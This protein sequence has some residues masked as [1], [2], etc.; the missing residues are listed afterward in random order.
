V[1]LGITSASRVAFVRNGK[2][3]DNREPMADILRDIVEALRIIAKDL[4]IIEQRIWKLE[5]E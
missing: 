2:I 3:V 4:E 5:H 1:A